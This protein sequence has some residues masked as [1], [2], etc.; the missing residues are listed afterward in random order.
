M[1]YE[2]LKLALDAGQLSKE[3]CN[4]VTPPSQEEI[5]KLSNTLEISLSDDHK[6]LLAEWGGSNLDE[7]RINSIERILE[8]SKNF[9]EFANDYNGF[10]FKYDE[11]GQ[12]YSE[13]TDGGEIKNIAD[14]VSDFINKFFLG[15]QGQ[16]FYGDD[17]IDELK[18]NN[19]I[20]E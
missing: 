3:M 10:V 13:D 11:N 20:S 1:K 2:K 17:W 15:I 14:S 5:T 9:V 7:I 6:E 16:E 18:K 4:L 19:L 12:V 8:S